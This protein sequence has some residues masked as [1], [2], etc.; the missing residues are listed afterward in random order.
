MSYHNAL[1]QRDVINILG[2]SIKPITKEQLIHDVKN[3]GFK[4][5]RIYNDDEIIEIL[6]YL[7]KLDFVKQHENKYE[8]FE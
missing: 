5:Q 8:W 2:N 1:L 6:E 4:N 7:V 3:R